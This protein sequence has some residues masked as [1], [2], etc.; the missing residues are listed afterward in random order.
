MKSD[1]VVISRN[2]PIKKA[3]VKY[4]FNN[5]IHEAPMVVPR[6]KNK[7]DFIRVIED[8]QKIKVLEVR[9]I[10]DSFCRIKLTTADLIAYLN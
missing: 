3:I 6:C 2:L 5:E 10:E 1:S 9:D 4:Y 7:D 8:C